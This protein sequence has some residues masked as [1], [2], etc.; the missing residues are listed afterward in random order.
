L[1]EFVNKKGNTLYI[2]DKRNIKIWRDKE[3]YEHFRNVENI[4][5]EKITL[6]VINNRDEQL[7]LSDAEINIRSL[8]DKLLD[9]I[10]KHILK[11]L[12]EERSRLARFVAPTTFVQ[13]WCKHIID[14]PN[15]NFLD[16]SQLIAKHLY[17]AMKGNKT[18]APGDLLVILYKDLDRGIYSLALLKMDYND[19]VTRQIIVNEDTGLKEIRL[20]IKGENFPNLRQ[21]LQKVAFLVDKNSL[22]NIDTD[23]QLLILDRQ[24]GED[25]EIADFFKKEF[26]ACEVLLTNENKTVELYKSTNRWLS[27]QPETEFTKKLISTTIHNIK[28]ENEINIYELANTVFGNDEDIK[29][30]HDKI[31]LKK[32]YL[33]TMINNIGDP[34]FKASSSSILERLIRSKKVKTTDNIEIV[35]PH[36]LLED[37]LEYTNVRR[38]DVGETICDIVIKGVTI[39]KG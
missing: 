33:S 31:S 29:E 6:H 36:D 32:S 5:I 9:W 16:R 27:I 39:I 34:D 25:G 22:V 24:Q 15:E 12:K 8:S 26:L 19:T 37:K 35:G 23:P 20:V 4:S 30:D 14:D 18:I 13:N 10:Q 3:M 2:D 11:S 21:K 7:I 28:S 38:N 1:Q 17:D